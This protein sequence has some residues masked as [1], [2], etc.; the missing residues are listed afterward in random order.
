[1]RSSGHVIG[2]LQKAIPAGGPVSVTFE[3]GDALGY[4]PVQASWESVTI[5]GTVIASTSAGDDLA[6]SP[7]PAWCRRRA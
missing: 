4:T 7:P 3:I 2:R 6:A 1:M 5:A